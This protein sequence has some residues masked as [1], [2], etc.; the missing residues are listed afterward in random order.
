MRNKASIR[1]AAIT[2]LQVI[3]QRERFSVVKRLLASSGEAG[4]AETLALCKVLGN[5]LS[6]YVP[7][8]GWRWDAVVG[9]CRRGVDAAI[10]NSTEGH[11]A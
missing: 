9:F 2:D 1:Y 3:S 8:A 11:F 5:N 4:E 7:S 10:L 6:A